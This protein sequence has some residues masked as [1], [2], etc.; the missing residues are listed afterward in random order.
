MLKPVEIHI[1]AEPLTHLKSELDPNGWRDFQAHADRARALMAGRTFWNISSTSKG[2]GV[3]EMLPRMVAYARGAGVDARWLVLTGTPAFFHITKRLLHALHGSSGDGSSLGAVERATYDEVIQ[4]NV[5][6]FLALVKPRDVVLL[7]DPQTGGL[8]PALAAAG[9]SVVWRCHVG[10]DTP[11][12]EVARAWE[13]LRPDLSAARF[14]IFSRAAYVPPQYADRALIIQPSIDI[15]AVKNQPM[16]PEVARA[17]LAT[18]GLLRGGPDMPAPVFTRADGVTGRVSRCADII[19]LGTGPAPDTPLIVQVSRW[20]PLKDAAGVLS[21][22]A[23]LLR[24][25]PHL[26]AEL[27][28]AGPAVTSVAD[29]PDA[30]TTLEDVLALWRRQSHFVRQ[31][32]HLACLPMADHEENAAIVNA[33]QRHAAVVTQKSLQEGFGLTITEAMWKARPVVASAVGGLQDQVVHMKNGLLIRNPEDR[34]EFAGAVRALLEAPEL[35]ALLGRRAHEH[36]RAHFT[37]TRHLTDFARLVERLEEQ[38]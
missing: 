8:G 17:I 10:C 3:A 34:T 21:G 28:L 31:R 2:G 27:V 9:A 36:V 35:A 32:I 16:A 12:A 14:I 23:L 37:A 22:F 26:R 5:E 33:L 25:S 15:F 30:A 19:R 7:H 1:Q 4:D 13:F 11:N 38:G 18:T 6:E 29:D 20:D 24:H